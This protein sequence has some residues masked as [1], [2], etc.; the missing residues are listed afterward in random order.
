MD[1]EILQA[2]NLL[3]KDLN[4]IATALERISMSLAR[5]QEQQVKDETCSSET[6]ATCDGL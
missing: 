1:S 2:A 5:L 3:S 6:C 4:R